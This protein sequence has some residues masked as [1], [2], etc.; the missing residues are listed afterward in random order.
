MSI[1]KEFSK[2]KIKLRKS[3]PVKS[4]VLASLI[5]GLQ[6]IEKTENRESFMDDVIRLAKSSV[7]KLSSVVEDIPHSS[8][9]YKRYTAEI[10]IYKSFL[11]EMVDEKELEI[12]IMEVATNLPENLKGNKGFGLIVKE[13][14]EKYGEAVDMKQA[15]NIIKG[16]L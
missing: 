9:L 14:K 2:E 5:G 4:A 15:S 1:I 10:K 13:I 16:V 11:P 3:N 12:F 6:S 8:D 7:K